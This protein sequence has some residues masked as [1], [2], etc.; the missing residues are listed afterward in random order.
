MGDV[1][2]DSPLKTWEEMDSEWRDYEKSILWKSTFD[3]F[4]VLCTDFIKELKI[5]NFDF[6][7]KFLDK[8][9]EIPKERF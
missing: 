4:N 8:E 9:N 1:G 5:A 7:A 6:K 3:E 2:V